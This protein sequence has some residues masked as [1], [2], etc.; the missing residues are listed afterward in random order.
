MVISIWVAVGLLVWR[1]RAESLRTSALLTASLTRVVAERMDRTL[2]GIDRLLKDSI[3]LLQARE[4]VHRDILINQMRVRSA[5]FTELRNMFML[6]AGGVVRIS[7]IASLEGADLSHRSYFQDLRTGGG[8]DRLIITSPLLSTATGRVGI[9]A[10]RPLFDRSGAFDGAVAAVLN[11]EF[12][13]DMLGGVMSTE[14]DRSVIAN[15]NGDVLARLPGQSSDAVASIR[16]GPLFS[17]QLPRSRSGTFIAESA[18]DGKKRMA[19]YIALERYPVVVSVGVT[20]E[21]ALRRWTFNALVIAVAGAAFTLLVAMI[22]TLLDRRDRA[23]SRAAA[24]LIASEERYR[25]LVEGQK[26]LI[27]RYLPDTTLV[28][29]NQAYAD[30]H[31]Q[32]RAVLMGKKWLD[33]V[34]EPMRADILAALAEMTPSS[35]THEDLRKVPRPGDGVERWIEWRTTAEFD[36]IGML[37]GFQTIGRDVTDAHAAEQAN[38]EREE[39]YRQIF[40]HNPAVKL[41]VDPATGM[42]VDANESAALFY[43]YP[44]EMLKSLRITDINILPPQQ[45]REEMAAVEREERMFLRF[46]HRLASGEIRDV[47]VYSSPFHAGGRP[48]LSSIVVDVTERNRFE[49][50]LAARS[51]E[52]ARSNAELEQF[53]YVASHDLRQ[54]LRMVSSYVTLLGRS[55]ADRLNPDESEFIGFAVAGVKR[56]DALILAL[57]EYSRVGRANE[58]RGIVDLGEAMVEAAANL[59]LGSQD[60]EA[61]LE[62][63]GTLP[64]VMGVR[65]ELVRLFQNLLGNAIKYRHP[66]RAPLIRVGCRQ[67]GGEWVVWVEDNGIG[68]DSKYFDRIFMM[69]QR[70]HAETEYEG[71]GIGLSICQKIVRTHGGRIWVES[72]P[73]QGSRFMV[74]FPAVDRTAGLSKP[75]PASV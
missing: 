61:R 29:F 62:V 16:T 32:P 15:L 52:L 67:D 20:V 63:E 1:E 9:L 59:G 49:A 72:E 22:A 2:F 14:V 64:M 39:I 33:V 7:T 12:F 48:Y 43:G 6:D 46:K 5:D 75:V 68:I 35:P 36:E 11:P 71:T 21:A 58:D 31:G 53:A 3:T 51:A 25:T 60:V 17:E 57:L 38:A 30:F 44:V 47:E 13:T 28:A 37:L 50:E 56:M 23:Q 70:L 42:I 41:L 40:H 45:V 18:F 69:F 24:A 66:D 73:V 54:P 55:L 19:S 65:G 10:L 74:A 34:P 27:H 4:D 8:Q 26:D